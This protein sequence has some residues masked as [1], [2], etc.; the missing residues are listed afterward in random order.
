MIV[1][2]LGSKPDRLLDPT[3]FDENGISYE[4]HL[5]ATAPLFSMYI[6]PKYVTNHDILPK[7][8]NR[9]K[10][11]EKVIKGQSTHYQ[12]SYDGELLG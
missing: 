2:P 1:G 12:F 3:Y 9:D 4:P 6:K 10:V 8:V 7:H 11:P 5:E